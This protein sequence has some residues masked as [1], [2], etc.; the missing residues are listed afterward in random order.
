MLKVL[1]LNQYFG[2]DKRH[3]EKFRRHQANS[4][5]LPGNQK[6]QVK[7]AYSMPREISLVTLSNGKLMNWS[8]DLHGTVSRNTYVC[9]LR[10]GG[11]ANQ[12]VEK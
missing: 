7:I 2:D 5:N 12:Q 10:L 9:S 11:L 1:T 3:V 4:V 6:D 8:P